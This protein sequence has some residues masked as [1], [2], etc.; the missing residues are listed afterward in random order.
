MPE[1]IKVLM[2]VSSLGMGGNVI[3]VMNFFRHL[4]KDRFQVDF[5]IYDDSK[6][7]FLEEVKSA[8]SQV[9]I[10]K[11]Q[12]QNKWRQLV[13]Q[14]RQVKQLLHD[15]HYDIIHCHSCSFIGIFRGAIPGWRTKG[16]KVIAH[17]HNPGMP[18]H[19]LADNFIRFC[20]KIF[21]SHI[22]DMGFSCSKES[23]ASKYTRHFMESSKFAVINNA[24][25]TT[26]ERCVSE[27]RAKIRKQYGIQDK[28]V[29]G[30][31]GRLEAQKNYLF[32]LDALK[33]YADKNKDFCLF[34]VGDGSQRSAIEEKTKTLDIEEYVILVGKVTQPEIFY[35]AMDV[36]VLPSIYEGFG[37]VN[38]EA[39]VS[40]LPC[41][42][43]EA[44]PTDVDISG[45][46]EFLKLEPQTWCRAFENAFENQPLERQSVTTSKYDLTQETIR[47]EG[48]YQS[49]LEQ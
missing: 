15:N 3:F 10:I 39:Q 7:D 14:M 6:M 42:V 33:L 44:V 45:R 17:A 40:G 29:I 26:V 2:S 20:F 23:G 47:L 28:F 13:S 8:G 22:V 30:S 43:S 5:V 18:K 1:K 41:I 4:N 12:H 38:I 46:V 37:F 19:T 9:Y 27:L 21:L 25:E 36:F 35:S 16:T 32:I 11:R 34:L 24:I 31:V 48:L 49:V